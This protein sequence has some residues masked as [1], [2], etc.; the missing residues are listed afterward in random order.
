MTH[1]TIGWTDE[2]DPNGIG[3]QILTEEGLK[4]FDKEEHQEY[5]TEKQRVHELIVKNVH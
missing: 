3:Y 2:S 5:L 1:R 4:V